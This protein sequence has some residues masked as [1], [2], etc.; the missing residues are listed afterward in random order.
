MIKNYPLLTYLL[1]MVC[2]AVQELLVPQLN[3][4][5]WPFDGH[6]R[7]PTKNRIPQSRRMSSLPSAF[8][9]LNEGTPATRRIE[10]QFGLLLRRRDRDRDL[11]LAEG[12]SLSS[13]VEGKAW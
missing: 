6:V 5:N 8:L 10:C 11:L 1:S 2:G 4:V 3:T 12:E 13:Q 7:R 9:E